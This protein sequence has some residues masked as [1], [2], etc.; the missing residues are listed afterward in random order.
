MPNVA[1]IVTVD[2]DAVDPANLQLAAEDITDAVDGVLPVVSVKPWARPVSAPQIPAL[3]Q[4][5]IAP[6]PTSQL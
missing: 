5:A 1:F 2:L 3:G 4:P 6:F